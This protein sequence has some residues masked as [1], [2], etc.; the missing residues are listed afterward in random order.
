ML[1]C[2]RSRPKSHY[3]LAFFVYG[4]ISSVSSNCNNIINVKTFCND[5]INQHTEAESKWGP[6]C[7]QHF[8]INLPVL[9]S[10]KF[11]YNYFTNAQWTIIHHWCKKKG[12]VLNRRQAIIYMT[13]ALGYWR[14]Y[15]SLG[16]DVIKNNINIVFGKPRTHCPPRTYIILYDIIGRMVNANEVCNNEIG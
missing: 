5:N 16:L 8:K 14:M 3:S 10:F 1:W 13:N 7:R 12:L 9:F 11:P 15:A 2:L 4:S 6:L